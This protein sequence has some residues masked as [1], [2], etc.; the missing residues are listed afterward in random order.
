M[1]L[2]NTE[3]ATDVIAV[4][5]SNISSNAG[6]ILAIMAFILGLSLVLALIDEAKGLDDT[7]GGKYYRSKI[8]GKRYKL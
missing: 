6:G 5:V 8:S 4:I 2:I 1:T 3:S 7:E